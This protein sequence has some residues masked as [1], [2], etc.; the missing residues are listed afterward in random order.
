[1]KKMWLYVLGLVVV[2]AAITGYTLFSRKTIDAVRAR[3][4]QTIAAQDLIEAFE[5]NRTA[6]HNK[7]VEKILRV[8]GTVIQVDS[9][10]SVVLGSKKQ[11]ASVVIGVDQR[12]ASDIQKVAEG[13]TAIFQ[14]VYSGYEVGVT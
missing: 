5:Q 7:Y 9:A 4:F 14:G 3:P 6:A 8:T 1:M 10:G 2:V 13:D 12:H 11:P